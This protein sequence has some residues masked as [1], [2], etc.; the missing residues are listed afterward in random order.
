MSAGP[1]P[2]PRCSPTSSPPT[3]AARPSRTADRVI[4]LILL[5]YGLVTVASAIPQLWHFAAFAGSWM[6]LAGI[7][8]TFTNT[9]QGDLW[10]RIGVG[11]F[12]VG[13][14]VTAALSVR[15]IAR[16]KLAWWIPLVGAIVTFIVVSVCLT[17]PLLG[18]PALVAH[19]GA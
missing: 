13:W 12:V 10:G 15:A 17:V 11:V 14:L 8:G 4:T 1:S 16:G 6:D 18:D 7:D 5:A 9:A 2:R 3:R 19:F